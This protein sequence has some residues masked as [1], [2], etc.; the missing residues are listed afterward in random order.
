MSKW[1]LEGY[2]TFEGEGY[3]LPGTYDTEAEAEAAARARLAD[4]EKMQPSATSGGQGFGGIQD[5]VYIVGP[6]GTRRIA[7]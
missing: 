4:L 5:R 1:R 2:D 6:A 3:S 7:R